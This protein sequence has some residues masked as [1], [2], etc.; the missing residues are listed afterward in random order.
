MSNVAVT[1][2][3]Q[4]LKR[5]RI[6]R[7]QA[8][9]ARLGLGGLY[10]SD[11]VSLQYVLNTKIPGAKLFVPARGEPVAIVRPRDEGYVAL[12][13]GKMIR[14]FYNNTWEPQNESKLE[15]FADGVADLMAQHGAAGEP[16]GVDALEA[17]AFHALLRARIT[18]TDARPAIEYAKSIKTQ[19]EIA[20]YRLVAD[21][22]RQTFSDFRAAIRPGATERELYAVVMG[23]WHGCGGEEVRQ[24]NVC[25]G[26]HMNPWRRWPT[27]RALE[28]GEMVGID[29]HG[30][31]V[32]GIQ[33]DVSRTFLVSGQPT[34][35]Q[36]DLYVRAHE[37]LDATTD[38]FRAGRAVADVVDAVPQ[39]PEK[40]YAQLYNY[41]IA[42]PIGMTPSGYPMVNM[43]RKPV[44][45]V[46]KENEVFA[47]ESYFGE[48][49]SQLAVKV[50]HMIRVTDGAPEIF[51]AS[52]PLDPVLGG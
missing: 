10:I 30:R 2:D 15:R 33:G 52:V 6:E 37:Y 14:P 40:Y 24:L 23:A 11:A 32:N 44:D 46:L 13:H 5:E 36:R 21:Q 12:L 3:D 35:E 38:L 27:D 47:I 9:M 26:E 8:E 49:R 1:W 19:D 22:Y 42:H 16:L 51:D 17:P 7:L 28:P 34:P 41:N 25:A 4:R 43:D 50:E 18:V 20:I 31:S 45:D 29:F 39:V 48:K